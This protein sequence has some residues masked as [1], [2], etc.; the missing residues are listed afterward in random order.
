MGPSQE[1]FVEFLDTKDRSKIF[2]VKLT[3]LTL[4]GSRLVLMTLR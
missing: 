2:D 3:R 1:V 4:S